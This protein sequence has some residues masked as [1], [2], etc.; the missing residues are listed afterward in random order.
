MVDII[1]TRDYIKIAVLTFV[2]KVFEHQIAIWMKTSYPTPNRSTPLPTDASRL[3]KLN[4]A[5]GDS[6]KVA[7][8]SLAKRMQLAY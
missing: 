8:S 6:D 1:Q 3:N 7:Q 2:E 4:S 5:I